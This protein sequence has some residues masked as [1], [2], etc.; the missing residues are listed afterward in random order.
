MAL[1]RCWLKEDIQRM[2]DDLKKENKGV[3]YIAKLS[4]AEREALFAKYSDPEAAKEFNIEFER[5]LILKK[6]NAAIKKWA[7]KGQK[8][9]WDKT[10]KGKDFITRLNRMESILDPNSKKGEMFLESLVKEKLGF[11]ISQADSAE[12]FKRANT[13]NNKKRDMLDILNADQKGKDYLDPLKDVDIKD[14]S[15]EQQKAIDEYAQS[16]VDF[17]NTYDEIYLK[18]RTTSWFEQVAGFIKSLW[19][20]G[21]ISGMA[22][23][24]LPSTVLL[25]WGKEWK[26]IKDQNNIKKLLTKDPT[27]VLKEIYSRPNFING[28][29]ETAGLGIGIREEAFPSAVLENLEQGKY[30]EVLEKA[31]VVGRTIHSLFGGKLGLFSRSANAYNLGI[32]L[33]RAN[34]YDMLYKQNKGDVNIFDKGSNQKEVGRMVNVTTGRGRATKDPELNRKIS[35][36]LFSL[37]LLTARMEIAATPILKLPKYVASKVS[38]N[39]EF[40]TID[41]IK[42]SSAGKFL[43]SVYMITFLLNAAIHGLAD[44][45]PDWWRNFIDPLSADFGKVKIGNT[46]FDL[47]LGVF[48]MYSLLARI[49]WGETKTQSGAYHKTTTGGLLWNFAKPK[50][51][52]LFSIMMDVGAGG[53]AALKGE[54]M[55]KEFGTTVF[56]PAWWLEKM[57]PLSFAS[58]AELGYD[59]ATND[60]MTT[61]MIVGQA[62]G[63]VGDFVGVSASTYENK[64]YDGYDNGQYIYLRGLVAKTGEEP[65]S[66]SL[67]ESS[68]LMKKLEGEK[69]EQ[70]IEEFQ[71]K[72][73]K[74]LYRYLGNQKFVSKPADEQMEELKKARNKI[75]SDLNV[76]Y[77]VNKRKGRK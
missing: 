71:L 43:G 15:A 34:H 11:Q 35:A 42:L 46:H 21:D 12:I 24:Q 74:E 60:K 65:P 68:N 8:A 1:T 61:G 14:L 54:E 72:W 77:H 37:R 41:K 19:A 44:D 38:K 13:V 10:P 63:V 4:S 64:V 25:A 2:F 40:D 28:G 62:L 76:K 17:Q 18:S 9:G 22:R 53:M 6:Q 31:G 36:T 32:Q 48:T 51:A 7:E 67:T 30:K 58:L 16:I 20:S 56:S 45:D 69:K 70:A 75:I 29:Y 57:I 27:A 3:F 26:A 49:A 23:Q 47:S 50:S 59:V 52:P 5:K 33:A 66:M 73:S 39:V 55:P